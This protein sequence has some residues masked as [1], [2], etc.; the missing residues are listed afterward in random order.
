MATRS[1]ALHRIWSPDMGD[2]N[3]G[4][5][6]MFHRAQ[7]H[8]L[9]GNKADQSMSEQSSARSV[10]WRGL[11]WSTGVMVCGAAEIC[12]SWGR[13]LLPALPDFGPEHPNSRLRDTS[14][15]PIITEHFATSGGG[16]RA[17][18]AG[19]AGWLPARW[20]SS[21]QESSW[22]RMEPPCALGR[23][24]EDSSRQRDQ[25]LRRGARGGESVG[26]TGRPRS[27]RVL[28]HLMGRVRAV[29]LAQAPPN[30]PTR[31][32]DKRA[33]HQLPSRTHQCHLRP[34]RAITAPHDRHQSRGLPCSLRLTPR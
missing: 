22:R 7:H 31:D 15:P 6:E 23:R 8:D 34:Q 18:P 11:S 9:K 14:C 29:S 21:H 10:E 3:A 16:S 26:R 27:C 28:S 2:S 17:I 5:Q 19:S 1:G 25:F 32:I 12:V 24:A 30:G 4:W 33:E 13:Q 20:P